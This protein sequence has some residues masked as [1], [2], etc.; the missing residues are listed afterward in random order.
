MQRICRPQKYE[1]GFSMLELMVT[2]PLM[3]LLTA[4]ML[5]LFAM[6]ASRYY[7]FLGDWEL[8]QQVRIPME[9]IGRDIRYS[10]EW[11]LEQ[12]NED[13][14]TF[15]IRRHYLRMEQ[16]NHEDYWQRYRIRRRQDGS[17]W[18]NKNTQ[19]M[20]GATDLTDV[21]L[22]HLSIKLLDEK[23]VKVSIA[24][25]NQKTGHRFALERVFYSYGYG[26][27]PIVEEEGATV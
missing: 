5:N 15:Y 13:D 18:I 26:L 1:A 23:R 24:G 2:L 20:I 7:D 25:L 6:A 8:I 19:P 4:A 9:E 3:M 11:R 14:Y 21:Y 27:T 12:D 10:G 22:E 16:Y 17:Y